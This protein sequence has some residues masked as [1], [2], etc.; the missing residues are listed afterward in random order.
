MLL[1]LFCH[2]VQAQTNEKICY[3]LLVAATDAP[4]SVEGRAKLGEL[5]TKIDEKKCYRQPNKT[6]LQINSIANLN[7]LLYQQSVWRLWAMNAAFATP[8][9]TAYY[10]KKSAEALKNPPGSKGHGVADTFIINKD[11]QPQ[12]P[13]G[14]GF[15]IL[16]KN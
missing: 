12:G 8:E 10:S 6:E 5:I 4:H 13:R 16:N 3:D 14:Y 15:P 9:P 1:F 2:G 11:P 7:Y